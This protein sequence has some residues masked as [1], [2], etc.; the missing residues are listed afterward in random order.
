MIHKFINFTAKVEEYATLLTTGRNKG[1]YA[2]D[3]NCYGIA[4]YLDDSENG[5]IFRYT[6]S[7]I[8]HE[9]FDFNTEEARENARLQDA[10]AD[11]LTLRG[12]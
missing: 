12:R 7:E 8:A 11:E 2:I 5:T 9:L 1:F 6:I 3:I 10:Y 4:P